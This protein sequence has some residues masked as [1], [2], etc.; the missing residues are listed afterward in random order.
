MIAFTAEGVQIVGKSAVDLLAT[1]RAG[2][3]RVTPARVGTVL[4]PCELIAYS[5]QRKHSLRLQSFSPFSQSPS[6]VGGGEI[7]PRRRE[8]KTSQTSRR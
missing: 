7:R 5:T 3:R 4:G 2:I 6:R 1:R 8:R